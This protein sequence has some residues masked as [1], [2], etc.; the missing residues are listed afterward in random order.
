MSSQITVGHVGHDEFTRLVD[1]L[2]SWLTAGLV[3]V[4]F[5]LPA[6]VS[7]DFAEDN[8]SLQLE[9]HNLPKACIG[10]LRHDI[11]VMV[12]GILTGYRNMVVSFLASHE[13]AYRTGG[14]PTPAE[15]QLRDEVLA[16]IQYVEDRLVTA[17]LRRHYAIKR[18][19]KNSIYLDVSWE[20]VEKRS[21]STGSPPANLDY[22]TVRITAQMPSGGQD[23]VP[24]LSPLIFDIVDTSGTESLTLTMTVE[25]L[26]DLLHALNKALTALREVMDTHREH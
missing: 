7:F 4:R 23:N 6:Q 25:D 20:V 26:S 1:L 5:R 9:K 22:A 10:Q 13:S 14:S 16:R 15:D 8:V 21:E 17:D 19:S 11:P 18:T 3:K 12:S 24:F 2:A